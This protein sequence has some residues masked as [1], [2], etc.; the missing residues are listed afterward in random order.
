MDTR[1][2]DAHFAAWMRDNLARA[3]D[4]FR[5]TVTG[6]PVH[7]W[8]L[9]SISAA[10]TGPEGDRWLRV[11]S[12]TPEWARGESWTGTA[13]AGA[14]TDIPMPAVL[15]VHEWSDGRRQ[16]AE[17]MTLMPGDPCSSSDALR[18]DVDLS[19]QWWTDLR[20]ALTRLA[21]IPTRRVN[22][23][24]TRVHERIRERFGDTVDTAVT[25]W[26]TVHG[27]LHW[28]NLMRPAFGLVDWELW[29]TGPA[30]TDEAT[31]YLYS[32]L[33]PAVAE[34][35]REMFAHTLDSPAGRVA[36]L[37]VAARLLRRADDG[38]HPD[39]GERVRRHAGALLDQR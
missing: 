19:A 20:Q 37:H 6:E 3:A 27:D 1:A 4:H 38:D 12:Q 13:D 31:L 5:L 29:G 8:R 18:H 14:I 30:G 22:A 7:G 21:G 24:Q 11:V 10:V 17:I 34:V 33:T 35:V 32:L 39:L 28:S 2:A 23:D 9:R 15:D 16:R 25:H 36:Q 26:V